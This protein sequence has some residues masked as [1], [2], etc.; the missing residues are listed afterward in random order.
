VL[1]PLAAAAAITNVFTIFIGAF[2]TDPRVL[3][4]GL[5]G[6]ACSSY[7][8]LFFTEEAELME[9]TTTT[10][11]RNVAMR[12]RWEIKE[13]SMQPGDR[14]PST[15]EI[16]QRFG[17]SRRT[18]ARALEILVYEKLIEVVSGRGCYVAG[19]HRSDKPKDSVEAY[20]R[21]NS[22]KG[23]WLPDTSHVAETCEVSTATVRR[24]INEHLRRGLL[25]KNRG[26]YYYHLP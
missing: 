11:Y 2:T 10:G 3:A 1:Q 15:Q 6:A 18:V 19:G 17:V 8:W 9:A 26:R 7:G 20:L 23:A 21:N 4:V 24:V 25:Y 12:L 14:L 22:R 16:A 5:I 13:E